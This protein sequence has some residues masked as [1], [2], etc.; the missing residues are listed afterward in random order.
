M[1]G[2]K[3]KLG[4]AAECGLVRWDTRGGMG[5]QKGKKIKKDESDAALA[6]TG[7]WEEQRL[8]TNG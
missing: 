8:G 1:H 2:R 4:S 5:I 7:V 6:I 3:Q